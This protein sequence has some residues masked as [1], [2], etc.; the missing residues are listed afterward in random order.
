MTIDIILGVKW[1]K[2]ALLPLPPLLG[3]R[4]SSTTNAKTYYDLPERARDYVEVDL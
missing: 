1:G 3:M 2:F 4:P